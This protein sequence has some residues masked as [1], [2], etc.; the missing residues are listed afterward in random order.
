MCGRAP[1]VHWPVLQEKQ[2]LCDGLASRTRGDGIVPISI[3][4]FA[5]GAIHG[6]ATAHF[7]PHLIDAAVHVRAVQSHAPPVLAMLHYVK[8]FG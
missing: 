8:T 2:K 4:G 5:V 3:D 7:R 1:A 6:E